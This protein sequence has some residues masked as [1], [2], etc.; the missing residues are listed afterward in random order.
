[1]SFGS[2]FFQNKYFIWYLMLIIVSFKFMK[3]KQTLF[4]EHAGYKR[5][6]VLYEYLTDLIKPKYYS[7]EYIFIFI[8]KSHS[9]KQYNM[10][11]YYFGSFIPVYCF[12]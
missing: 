5:R 3:M 6:R 4:Y 7:V 11:I 9:L 8:A 2:Y 1:M 12:L 10:K